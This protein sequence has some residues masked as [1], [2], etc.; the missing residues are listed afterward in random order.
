MSGEL[1]SMP[2]DFER[3][4]LD[5][6]EQR[7]AAFYETMDRRRSVREFS[8]EPVPRRLVDQAIRTASTAPSGAHRQPWTF[9]VVGEP[10]LK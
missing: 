2:Y 9:V 8:D 4:P 1:V 3:Y 10:A 5:I 7:A 6:M